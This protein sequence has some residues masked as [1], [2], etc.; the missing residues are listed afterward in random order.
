[1]YDIPRKGD[2]IVF[3]SDSIYRGATGIVKEELDYGQ[4]WAYIISID[5][6]EDHMDNWVFEWDTEI[7]LFDGSRANDDVIID[8]PLNSEAFQI[9]DVVDTPDGIQV[10][11]EIIIMNDKIPMRYM[12]ETSPFSDDIIN[13]YDESLLELQYHDIIWE[14][15]FVKLLENVLPAWNGELYNLELTNY[16]YLD[17]DIQ[18]KYKYN[19]YYTNR[20]VRCD[21]FEY[22]IEDYTILNR[23]NAVLA[24]KANRDKISKSLNIKPDKLYEFKYPIYKKVSDRNMAD[25]DSNYKKKIGD[26]RR[27]KFTDLELAFASEI[28]KLDMRFGKKVIHYP[29]EMTDFQIM[30]AIKEAYEN[31]HRIFNRKIGKTYVLKYILW[32]NSEPIN[33]SILF[34]GYSQKYKLTIQFLYNFD[35]NTIEVAY[36]IEANKNEIKKH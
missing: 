23:I 5:G 20:T 17:D 19:D 27:F 28:D 25:I 31:S 18:E 7:R 29:L 30:E 10:V 4:D 34:E 36:P 32:N 11:R 24:I 26:R 2:R 33:G 35:L 12:Y 15:Y 6:D 13:R 1:M 8:K 21:I 16:R 14:D 9:G 22:I 3:I